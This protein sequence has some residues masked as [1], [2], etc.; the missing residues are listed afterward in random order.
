MLVVSILPLVNVKIFR[1]IVSTFRAVTP[2]RCL[3]AILPG[4]STRA[5][6]LPD[7]PSLDRGSREVE[8]GFEPLT[9]RTVSVPNCHATRRKH[10]GWD[11]ARLFKPR[12]GKSR[13]R[14]RARTKDPPTTKRA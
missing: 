9:F 12:G 6:I 3:T 10:D 7:C 13:G 4:E 8:V 11:T 14:D 5:G 2:F 1:R